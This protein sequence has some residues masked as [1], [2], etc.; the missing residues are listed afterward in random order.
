MAQN[1]TSPADVV[2]PLLRVRQIREFTPEPVSPDDL[3]ALTD[4]ARWSGSSSNEQPWRFIA[5]RDP[6]TIKALAGAYMPSSRSLQTATAAIAIV[7]P[8][9][10]GKAVMR[11]F[12]EG[13]AA[14][15]ILD[16]ATSLGLGAAISWVWVE[17]R[18][19]VQELLGVPEGWLVR[20]IMALGHPS[21][22][23]RKPKSAP[24]TARKPRAETVFDERWRG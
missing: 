21:A 7:V 8:D 13:R 3:L 18:P 20:T 6:E 15:R 5:I 12:D 14:E 9:E 23:A 4:V 2:R 16:A 10:P 17:A 24:G 11:G 1:V 22:E 19:K